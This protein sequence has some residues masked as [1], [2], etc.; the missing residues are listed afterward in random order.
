[1]LDYYVNSLGSYFCLNWVRYNCRIW[2]VISTTSIYAYDVNLLEFCKNNDL[3]ILNGRLG[4]DYILPKLTCKD[5]STID[6][7]LASAH[8]LQ[9]IENFQIH[10][11]SALFS[12]VHCPISLV[13]RNNQKSSQS[14]IQN[15]KSKTIPK[16]WKAENLDSFVE[17]FDILKV[18]EIENKLDQISEYDTATQESIDET[19]SDIGLLFQRCCKES[20]GHIKITSCSEKYS[21]FKPRFNHNC[22]RTRNLYHKTR[23]MYNKSDYYKNLLKLVSKSYKKTLSR[24]N[25]RFNENKIRKLRNL[26][27]SNPREYWNTINC[28]KYKVK[29]EAP[30][31]DFYEFFRTLNTQQNVQNEEQNDYNDANEN[32]NDSELYRPITEAEI[33]LCTKML[34]NNK[35]PGLDNILN[36]HIKSTINIMLPVYTKLFNIIYEK[37]IM[38]E[39]WTNGNIKPIFKNKGD[40]QLPENYRPITL[41]SCLGKLFTAI[42]NDS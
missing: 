15:R 37:G 20:F 30:L 10:D 4:E 42:I 36:E 29:S 23:K 14:K 33:L 25:N 32:D 12:D 38:P 22:I 41:L 34:K 13:I 6:Y 8:V 21:S 11:F 27:K 7:F 28:E 39:S 5:K 24:E 2:C 1:M 40:P 17:N 3:F 35:S 26:K 16:L 31:N 18:S 9:N 19:V